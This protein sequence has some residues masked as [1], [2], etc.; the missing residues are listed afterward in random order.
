LET[1]SLAFVAAGLLGC[2]V[3]GGQFLSRQI[4]LREFSGLKNYGDIWQRQSR[5]TLLGVAST[6]ATANV[7]AYLVT[8]LA[9]P[10]AFAPIAAAALFI[11]PVLL[12]MSSLTQLE[13]PILGRAIASGRFAAAASTCQRFFHALLLIWLATAVLACGIVLY[14]P[15]VVIKPDYPLDTMEL[16]VVLLLAT[17]LMQ[18]WQGPNSALLQA[19]REFMD[20]SKVSVIS[21]VF[22]IAGVVAALALLPPV[23]SL[24]GVLSGQ[25]AMA[26][27]LARLVRKWKFEHARSPEMENRVG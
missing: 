14:A 4:A 27:L 7:H 20:L 8:L 13:I 9:G 1:V 19:A 16:A 2:G 6:E 25:L 11:R 10:A 12:A 17:S 22:S 24:V 23:Y 21:S 3:L 5:W 15:S 18:V 26:L